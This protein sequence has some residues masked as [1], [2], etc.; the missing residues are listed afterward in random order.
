MFLELM[1]VSGCFPGDPLVKI[2]P[3]SGGGAASVPRQGAKNPHASWPKN[4]N[5]KQKQCCNKFNKDFINGPHKNSKVKNFFLN[6]GYCQRN[7]GANLAHW[8]N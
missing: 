6:S 1:G 8:D 7:T 3:S 4:Q 5:V 2:S